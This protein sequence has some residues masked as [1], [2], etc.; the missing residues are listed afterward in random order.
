MPDYNQLNLDT[1][2]AAGCDRPN[3]P[4]IILHSPDGD[5]TPLKP[6]RRASPNPVPSHSEL[7]RLLRGQ[8]RSKHLLHPNSAYD[9]EPPL[10]FAFRVF[11]R[12][13]LILGIILTFL[14]GIGRLVTFPSNKTRRSARKRT[15]P[16]RL[17]A[18]LNSVR[19][20]K[21]RFSEFKE[22]ADVNTLF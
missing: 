1:S 2:R 9:T 10:P 20:G 12:M 6:G 3:H 11:F 15:R 16:R 17:S 21:E 7:R 8:V 18:T 22:R 14:E 19:D 5:M 13:I 4:K